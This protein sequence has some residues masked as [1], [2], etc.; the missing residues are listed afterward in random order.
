[1]RYSVLWFRRAEQE[2]ARIWL[3]AIDRDAISRAANLLDKRLTRN[4]EAEGESRSHDRRFAFESPLGIL[5][6]VD[7]EARLVVVIHVWQ[8]E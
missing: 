5:F 7:P 4:P 2:M 1:M 6:Q 8:Y 3:N